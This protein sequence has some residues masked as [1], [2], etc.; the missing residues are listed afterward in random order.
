MCTYVV[1]LACSI[2]GIGIGSEENKL[3]SNISIEDVDIIEVYLFF[4]FYARLHRVFLRQNLS[5]RML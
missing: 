4:F 5:L 1:A 3:S 2:L